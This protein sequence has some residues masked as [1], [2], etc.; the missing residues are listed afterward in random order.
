MEVEKLRY[1]LILQEEGSVSRAANRLY[2]SQP[3]LSKILSSIEKTVGYKLF[4]RTANGLTPTPEGACYLR[5]A[6]EAVEA[7]ERVLA[8]MAVL[9]EEANRRRIVFGLAHTR[10]AITILPNMLSRTEGDYQVSIRILREEELIRG[11]TEGSID[12]AMLT[13]SRS[14]SLPENLRCK[15]LYVERILIGARKDHPICSHAVE[16][17]ESP[18]PYL[19][20]KYLNGHSMILSGEGTGLYDICQAFFRANDIC[21]LIRV[22]EDSVQAAKRFAEEGLGICFVNKEM[23]VKAP[24]E[25]LQFFLTD[26]S[27]P[28]RHVGLIWKRNT[29]KDLLI[30]QVIQD[31]IRALLKAYEK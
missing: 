11:V 19:D 9:R 30:H 25:K 28:L 27:M 10:N 31:C 24:S 29:E 21:P 20:P 12:F 3:S 7:E 1:L 13:L 4:E 26:E 6:R 5:Y 22:F 2:L 14:R 16:M 23:V 17:L 18:Y 8:E 15:E